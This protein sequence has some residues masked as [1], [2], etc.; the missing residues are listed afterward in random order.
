MWIS[1]QFRGGKRKL[2][3]EGL[4][5]DYIGNTNHSPSCVYTKHIKLA[6]HLWPWPN[7][8]L[9]NGTGANLKERLEKACMYFHSLGLTHCHGDKPGPAFWGMRD[10]V[11]QSWIMSDKTILHQPAPSRTAS[12]IQMHEWSRPR[13]ATPGSHQQNHPGCSLIHGK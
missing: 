11:E 7:D 9:A 6:A 1:P 8:I 4:V 2:S 10:Y 5:Y 13:S 3:L 12:C